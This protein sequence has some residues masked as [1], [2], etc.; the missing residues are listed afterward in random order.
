MCAIP[1]GKTRTYGDLARASSAPIARDIGQCLRR[2]PAAARH[3]LPPHRRR[4]RHRR[5]R[6][7]PPSG[8]LLEAKRW[9]LMHEA[10]ATAFELNRKHAALD[11]FC[12]ALWLE[13]G[14]SKNTIAAY[15]ADLEQLAAFLE[16]AV[17]ADRGSR[18]CSRFLASRGGRASSAARRVSTP[19][20]LLPLLPARAADRRRPDA[21]ARS[22]QAR[23]ALS[24]DARRRPTSRRCSLRRTPRRR[25][26]CAT[27]R[28]S[29]RCTRPGCASPS[30]SR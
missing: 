26:A 10:A 6:A 27:G 2:Q 30:W 24:E 19:E 3:S 17:R 5:L 1:R 7:L 15:R 11:A 29:K 20:A 4:R 18:T 28:C 14:L 8:Y 23:A 9:L 13:D 22:A 21:Q 16:E 12:D 25:S